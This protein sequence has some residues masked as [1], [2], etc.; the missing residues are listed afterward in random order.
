LKA[1]VVGLP[2]S[3]STLLCGLIHSASDCVCLSEPHFEF[4]ATIKC[5]VLKD[6]KIS[7]LGLQ[8]RADREMPMD[9]PMSEL[10]KTFKIAAF[11]ETFRPEPFKQWGL[12]N[13]D[14]LET[15]KRNQYKVIGIVRSPINNFNS[16]K[17]KKWGNWT[18]NV[19]I[20]IE[21]YLRLVQFCDGY[22]IRYEDLLS[23][24]MHSLDFLNISFSGLRPMTAKFGD[25]EALKS[26]LVREE[27]KNKSNLSQREIKAIVESG[28]PLLYDSIKACI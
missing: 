7:G 10:D 22:A 11:K 19:D 27:K 4:Q 9:M 25:P 6:S 28:L 23:S 17:A 16:W 21:S 3:G 15:Y 12:C 14:L 5:E 18:D 24:P 2:R 20:F 8:F 1:I 13:E 26:T